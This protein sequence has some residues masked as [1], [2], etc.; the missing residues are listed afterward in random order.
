ME[1]AHE[2]DV[3]DPVEAAAGVRESWL[4]LAVPAQAEARRSVGVRTW[5][6]TKNGVRPAAAARARRAS[7]CT[8]WRGVLGVISAKR[9][10]DMTLFP[11]QIVLRRLLLPTLAG[12]LA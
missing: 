7:K 11:K 5:V 2:E 9:G 3:R 6:C 8:C 4:G 10:L 12:A 1:R